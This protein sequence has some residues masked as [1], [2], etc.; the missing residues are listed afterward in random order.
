MSGDISTLCVISA[1]HP[2]LWQYVYAIPFLFNAKVLFIFLSFQRSVLACRHP[3]R[4]AK[5]QQQCDILAWR[6]CTV[7][8][9]S[10]KLPV[11]KLK[12][13]I[14]YRYITL[15]CM[16]L[17]KKKEVNWECF[18]KQKMRTF[19]WGNLS[20]HTNCHVLLWWN[21]VTMETQYTTFLTQNRYMYMYSSG[22][23]VDKSVCLWN[24]NALPVNCHILLIFI[25]YNFITFITIRWKK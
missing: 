21:K 5:D 12:N 7:V 8:D 11:D 18:M 10:F 2:V 1:Y 20:K 24:I 17:N 16:Y 9:S 15:T 22:I 4:L 14:C 6:I 3:W 23:V 19:L 25:V 13:K